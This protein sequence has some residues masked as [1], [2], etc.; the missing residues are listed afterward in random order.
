M[1]SRFPRRYR[2]GLIEADGALVQH[3]LHVRFPRRY[4]RGLIEA[5][6]TVGRLA[7]RIGFRGDIAAAS[8]KLRVG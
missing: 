6:H 2:R 1:F 8:L 4:R 7:A 5:R 3:I